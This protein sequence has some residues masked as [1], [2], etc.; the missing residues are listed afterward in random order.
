MVAGDE[1]GPVFD[2]LL[3]EVVTEAT[4][5]VAEKVGHMVGKDTA[6]VVDAVVLESSGD[7]GPHYPLGDYV[8]KMVE[9]TT[10]PHE[11]SANKHLTTLT[12]DGSGEEDRGG[13]KKPMVAPGKCA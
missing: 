11:D 13:R 2:S 1:G 12:E 9:E 6:S 10:L 7:D 4:R 5:E 3:N 8:V